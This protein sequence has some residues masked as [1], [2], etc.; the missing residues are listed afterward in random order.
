MGNVRVRVNPAL[1]RLL[2][3]EVDDPLET[4]LEAIAN[5]A[6]RI[7]PVDTGKLR[8]SIDVL[9]IVDHIGRVGAG[10]V[11]DGTDKYAAVVEGVATKPTPNYPEQPYLRPALYRQREIPGRG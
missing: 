3:A 7:C 9:G 1:D 11:E 2:L 5:D 4:V 8:A 10:K 6:R